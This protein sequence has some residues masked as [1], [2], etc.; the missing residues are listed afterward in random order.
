MCAPGT[1]RRGQGPRL[2][3]QPCWTPSTCIGLKAPPGLIL[4]GPKSLGS[5][6]D[7]EHVI[8]SS[9]VGPGNSSSHQEAPTWL[10]ESWLWSCGGGGGALDCAEQGHPRL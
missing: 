4:E 9:R 3:P 6:F 2:E 8:R 5:V 10:P 7:S 1:W